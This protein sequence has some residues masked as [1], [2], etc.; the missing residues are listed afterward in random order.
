MTIESKDAE[1][2]VRTPINSKIPGISS[3]RAIGTCISAGSPRG[4]VKNP[5]KP[6]PNFPEPWAIKITPMVARN[7]MLTIS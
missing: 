2:L 7:P 3:A 4:P 5:A 6:G 1:I